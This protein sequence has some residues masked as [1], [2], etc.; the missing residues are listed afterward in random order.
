MAFTLEQY[1]SLKSAIATGAT[2]VYYGDKRVEYRD[3]NEMYRILAQ[4]EKDLGLKTTKPTRK[5]AEFNKGLQ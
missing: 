4:M 5:Y 3:L 2:A 1:N